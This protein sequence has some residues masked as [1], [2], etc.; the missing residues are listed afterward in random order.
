MLQLLSKA[1]LICGFLT[2]LVVG[3]DNLG[4]ANGYIDIATSNFKARIV[5]N[6]QVL[7]SLTPTGSS[8]DFLPADKI[9]NRARNGVYHWGDITYRYRQA[10]ATSW[11]NA[12]S[13]AS[14]QPITALST[15]AGVYANSDLKPTLPSGPL[16]VTREWLDVSGDLGL[17]FTIK[18]TGTSSVEIG[19]LGFPAEFNSIFTNRTPLNMQRQCSLSDPY[20]GMDAGHI[21]VT[22]VSGVGA[23]LV[24]TPLNGTRTPLEAYRNLNEPVVA[25]TGYGSQTFEGLYEWQVYSKAY[26]DSE[27]SGKTPWNSA[28]SRII[29]AGQTLQ[30]GVR[31][32]L[33][34]NGIRGLDETISST[35]TP[36]AVGV[37]GYIIP[38]D[39][40]AQLLIQGGGS[41]AN[42]TVSPAGALVVSGGEGRR[43]TLTPS[44]SAWGR[45]RLSVNYSD[46]RVQTIHYYITKPS[47]DTLRDLGKF[48]TTSAWFNKPDDPFKRSPSVMTYD[49]EKRA[50]VEQDS[51]A[52]VAGLS[53]EGG[54]GAYL[55]A[56]VKQTILPN[57]AEIAKLE[58]FVNDVIWGGI[59][60]SDFGVRKALFFYEPSAA[61][62]YAYDGTINWGSWTSWNKA[63]SSTVDRAYNYV[64]VAAAYWSM[65][66]VARAYPDTVTRRTWDWYLNQAYQTAARIN[67][68][69][70]G[71]R[72]VGLMGETVFGE[73]LQ[74][75]KREG[76]STEATSLE[77]IMRSRATLWN[78][79]EIPYG[80]EMAWDSTGQE[81][82]YYW[83]R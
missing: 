28:S 57:A 10:G 69:D 52:W 76:K 36:V 62:G 2:G 82:V 27:W 73:I 44:S 26:A 30:F 32:S 14:R 34:K 22:P 61:P 37:P 59:Q 18:N 63:A 19:S 42:I 17:R 23:A 20:I 60:R 53:D 5:R 12:D 31:F 55:A 68:N 24:V 48:L 71:Y 1:T 54:V 72:D 3:Q 47:Q 13:A 50:I 77:S 35:G 16:Q 29:A 21:R 70:V 64:H 33:S 25:D 15:G 40:P 74:D 6:A 66:R 81:G 83:T 49:I 45:V 56:I 79:Q 78:S 8:F 38:R 7:V 43:Y 80:S 11:T 65:Y 39:L 51:R 4:L 67:K 75:L 9:S 58:T 41:I 46:N